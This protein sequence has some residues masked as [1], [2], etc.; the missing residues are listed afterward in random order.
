MLPGRHIRAF[1]DLVSQIRDLALAG[2]L[3][4]GVTVLMVYS[5]H[6]RRARPLIDATVARREKR[7]TILDSILR[8]V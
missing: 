7:L 6:T 1:P 5:Q 2:I 3:P 4:G 8:V